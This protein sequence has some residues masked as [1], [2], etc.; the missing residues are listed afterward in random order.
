MN[1]ELSNTFLKNKRL[2]LITL[3][4]FV[5]IAPIFATADPVAIQTMFYEDVMGLS[6]NENL[7]L[8]WLDNNDQSHLSL[9]PDRNVRQALRMTLEFTPPGENLY[10]PGEIEIRL[11]RGLFEDRSGNLI[12]GNII[13]GTSGWA[14]STPPAAWNLAQNE[15]SMIIPLPGPT[16]FN[17]TID[18]ATNEIVISNFRP[19]TGTH[20]HLFIEFAVHYLPSQSPNGFTSEFYARATFATAQ[21]VAPIESNELSLDLTTRVVPLE[22]TKQALD[23]RNAWQTAWGTQP[24]GLDNH[25][26]VRYRLFYGMHQETTQPFVAFL[27]DTP[28]DSGQ[29][30]AWSSPARNSNMTNT[31][32]IGGWTVGNTAA[33]N[34]NADRTWNETMPLAT[35]S[36]WAP[37]TD[38]GNREWRDIIV[39]YPRTGQA[40]QLVRNNMSVVLTPADGSAITHNREASYTFHGGYMEYPGDLFHLRKWMNSTAGIVT[41][42][43]E[44]TLLEAGEDVTL[45]PYGGWGSQI[46]M[47]G[48][49]PFSLGDAGLLRA[50]ARGF[51][52]TEGGTEPFT[53]TAIDDHVYLRTSTGL[54]LLNPEDYRFTRVQLRNYSETIPLV[55]S[56]GGLI[57]TQVVPAANRSPIH[58]YYYTPSQ[59]WQH[60]ATSPTEWAWINL[61]DADVHRVKVVHE[62]GRYLTEFSLNFTMRINSTP[63]V[64]NLIENQT[65][66]DVVNFAAMIVE[67]YNGNV[68]NIATLGQYAS[69]WPSN[70]QDKD[71]ADYGHLVQ[72]ASSFLRMGRVLFNSPASKQIRT[73]SAGPGIVSDAANARVVFPYRVSITHNLGIGPSTGGNIQRPSDALFAQLLPEQTEGVFYDLLPQGTILNP[74]SIV[75]RDAHGRV[76]DHVLLTSENW[77]GSGRTLV[78]IY[79]SAT[80]GSNM[81]NTWG[82]GVSTTTAAPTIN[83]TG[84]TVDFDVFYPWANISLFGGTDIRNLVSY[85]SRSGAF[86]TAVS[87]GNP[88]TNVNNTATALTVQERTWMSNFPRTETVSPTELNTTSN[89]LSSNISPVVSDQIGFRKQ[90][91]A[92]NDL[93]YSLHT[94]LRPGDSYYYRLQYSTGD[95]Q[96]S[97]LVLFDVL[98]TADASRPHWRGNLT[99]VDVTQPIS[100]GIAPVVYYSTQTGL[101]PITNAAHANLSNA[102]IWSTTAP[103][104][105][106]TVTAVAIDLST[107]SNGQPFVFAAGSG[108]VINLHMQAPHGQ[109]PGTHAFNRGVYRVTTIP[110]TGA[111]INWPLAETPYAQVEILDRELT[112]TKTSNPTSGTEQ[113]PVT[114]ERGS[115][116]TYA[117]TVQNDEETTLQDITLQDIIPTHMSFSAASL[118]GHFGTASPQPLGDITRVTFSISQ[119]TINWTLATL[120]AGESFTLIVPATVAQQLST[121]V[122]FANTA[123]ITQVGTA[124]YDIASNTT[125]HRA[126]PFIIPT[127]LSIGNVSVPLVAVVMPLAILLALYFVPKVKR[128]KSSSGVV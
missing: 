106:N 21:G 126:K 49:D 58:L 103:A 27:Q 30:V 122:I 52:F 64:R 123:R 125:F 90:V 59:G 115:T 121:E 127:G 98:E 46:P 72:R 93:D 95:M 120:A 70:L 108:I 105:L 28:L 32:P 83:G 110:P 116:V 17:Y 37:V 36:Q 9:D 73:S 112:L 31:N 60:L 56:S 39:A 54:H 12:T 45:L 100:L 53:T 81:R 101:N 29:I 124:T 63:H 43:H 118:T 117:I 75:A 16:D 22:S 15:P 42:P 3:F 82:T 128:A 84:F 14:G 6:G 85:Q 47:G 1:K 102:A 33:F 23:S 71:I 8:R 38:A 62:N 69:D 26:F 94:S 74:A 87:G 109:I 61:P 76:V 44:L 34:S 41:R 86:L 5:L 111:P 13:W 104:N 4:A 99:S 79:V 24:S 7:T 35:T 96:A 10:E 89:V 48:G 55:S 119:N 2:V 88:H 50:E 25:F 19:V 18:T 57:D 78:S 51:G 65:T 97:S 113:A 40:E 20:T 114:V 68:R 67:D 92:A 66:V 80:A 77:Q 11:P 91:R 107:G